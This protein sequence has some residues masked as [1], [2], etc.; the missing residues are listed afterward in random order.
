MYVK[1]QDAIIIHRVAF[2]IG[3]L[4]AKHCGHTKFIRL[5]RR[6]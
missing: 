2:V 4:P 5:K 1:E 3:N 6:K